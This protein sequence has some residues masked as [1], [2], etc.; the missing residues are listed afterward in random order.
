MKEIFTL[1]MKEALENAQVLKAAGEND[2]ATK[3]FTKCVQETAALKETD[4]LKF[5]YGTN[6]YEGLSDVNT[7]A[8]YI[9]IS[10]C[11]KDAYVLASAFGSV[12]ESKP[13][14]TPADESDARMLRFFEWLSKKGRKPTDEDSEHFETLLSVLNPSAPVNIKMAEYLKKKSLLEIIK[15]FVLGTRK[16]T[17]GGEIQ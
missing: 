9:F 7:A 16:I 4:V 5:F 8:R 1:T 15:N 14:A 13:W 12:K 2:A 11:A 6:V 3:L 17:D 10:N